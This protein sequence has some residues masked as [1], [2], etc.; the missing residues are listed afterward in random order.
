MFNLYSIRPAARNLTLCSILAVTGLMIG[1]SSSDDPDTSDSEG[2]LTEEEDVLDIGT[3]IDN[4]NPI[5]G[6]DSQPSESIDLVPE[7]RLD[8]VAGAIFTDVDGNTLYTRYTDEPG[9]ITCVLDCVQQWP[10]LTT[11]LTTQGISGNFDVIARED[12]TSQWT[13]LGY[14]LYF[15]AGDAAPGDINGDGVD[16]QWALA[17]PI[18]TTSGDI[19]GDEALVALGSTRADGLSDTRVN[20]NN[21]T[22]YFFDNDSE[23]VSTCTEGCAT[24]WPPL[25]ADTGSVADGDRYTLIT[26]EDGSSQWAYDGKAL[27]F[28]QGDN[29]AG[30][31]SGAD[32]PN[33]SIARP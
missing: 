22:L 13:L 3:D 6:T 20:K 31:F 30:E 12:G 15:F 24:S 2:D 10:P 18:P 33:W 25:Y 27:Y 9:Q 1:C 11:S 28:W 26:R 32:V 4:P 29:A 17:R 16:N 23:G 7:L 14:P 5:P 19:D 21:F 8:D